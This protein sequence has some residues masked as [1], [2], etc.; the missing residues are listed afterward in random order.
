[1]R[2]NLSPKIWGRTGWSFLKHCA[3]ACDEES[4]PRYLDFLRLLPEVLP[5]EKCR[6]H[7]AE[8][9]AHNPPRRGEDLAKWIE[10][11]EASVRARKQE[12]RE[13]ASA[14]PGFTRGYL[15]LGLLLVILVLALCCISILV[16]IR[17]SR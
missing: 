9:L 15:L 13:E 7:A 12:E 16:C 3:E 2:K 8:Y 4:F 5:C 17:G 6:R 11:F 10:D 14:G 1:M